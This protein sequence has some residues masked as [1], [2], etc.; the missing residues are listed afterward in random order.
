MRRG[1]FL[2]T[3][4]FGAMALPILNNSS[5][6]QTRPAQLVKPK[7][8]QEGDTIALTA[9]AGIVYG[10]DEF[11]R[12]RKELES[13]GLNVKFGEFVRK[14]YGYLSGTDQQRAL[15]LNRFFA[16]RSVDAIMA[17]RGGWGC[18]RILPYLDFGLIARNPKI[19]CGFSDNT[20]L[21]LA[22]LQ[23]CGMVS[24]HGP[25]GNSDWT[26]LTKKSFRDVLMDG[27]KAAF[28]SKSSVETITAGTAEG[29]LI[30]GNLTILTT[31]LGTG[32]QPDLNGAILFVEDVGEPVY[33]VDRMMTHLARA[34]M[35]DGIKGFIFGRCTDCE[36]GSGDNKFTMMEIFHHHIKPLGVPAIYGADIGHE[37]DNFTIPVGITA[38]LDASNGVFELQES[39]VS[40][41]DVRNEM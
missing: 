19:Y 14:K 23:K 38:R 31:A 6:V 25:N 24:Y 16:D 22:F 41:D 33:K 28:H 3:F 37:E 12:M 20:T 7:R 17:V 18:A 30:G 13:F 34:G 1:D 40:E 10:D 15:D 8:L 35:L 27:K 36:N 39:G 5:A 26:K 4:G 21:H 11:E 2:K 32:Y 9:P 29:P